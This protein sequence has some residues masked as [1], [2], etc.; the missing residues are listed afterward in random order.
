LG[1]LTALTIV[2]HYA[3]TPKSPGCGNATILDCDEN[4]HAVCVPGPFHS[5]LPLALC[6]VLVSVRPVHRIDDIVIGNV[7]KLSLSP[8]TSA[9][10]MTTNA[11]LLRVRREDTC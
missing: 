5:A 9:I 4:H 3:I 10:S 6:G 2:E 7:R 8:P 11:P 1:C